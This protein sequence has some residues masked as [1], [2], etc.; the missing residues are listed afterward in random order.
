MLQG[1]TRQILLLLIAVCCG[2]CAAVPA[3]CAAQQAEYFYLNEPVSGQDRNS[4]AQ[5]FADMRKGKPEDIGG[6]IRNL[7]YINVDYLL[8]DYDNSLSSDSRKNYLKYDDLIREVEATKREVYCKVELAIYMRN[9]PQFAGPVYDQLLDEAFLKLEETYASAEKS[10][11]RGEIERAIYAFDLI[12]PYKDAYKKF[13]DA[14]DRSREL[15]G[16]T[17]VAAADVKGET[18]PSKPPAE[19]GPIER[20]ASVPNLAPEDTVRS[21]AGPIAV[22]ARLGAITAAVEGMSAETDVVEPFSAPE[23][24]TEQLVDDPS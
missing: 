1:F 4:C 18:E 21:G 22:A 20:A 15:S 23:I 13:L 24:S 3:Y 17:A 7:K 8:R 16:E 14:S 12:A 10:L 9:H 5:L 19:A 2:C 11:K 6:I